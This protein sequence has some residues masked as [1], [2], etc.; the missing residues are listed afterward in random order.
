[1]FHLN[2][3]KDRNI[4]KLYE[5]IHDFLGHPVCKTKVL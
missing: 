4:P 5:K 1:M 2:L 3:Q